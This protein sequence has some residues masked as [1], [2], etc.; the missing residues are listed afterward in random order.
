MAKPATAIAATS[1][2]TTILTWVARSAEWIEWFMAAS[3]RLW[4]RL[5]GPTFTLGLFQAGFVDSAKWFHC[6]PQWDFG[7]RNLDGPPRGRGRFS[8]ALWAGRGVK[9]ACLAPFGALR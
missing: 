3:R 1:A 2:I 4:R 8:Q 5:V 9:I 6:R 7:P